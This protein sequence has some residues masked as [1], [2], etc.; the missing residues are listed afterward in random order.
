MGNIRHKPQEIA[1]KLR[2]V[3]VLVSTGKSVADAIRSIGVTEMTDYRWRCRV[4]FFK[5]LQQL[6]GIDRPLQDRVDA[7]ACRRKP[8]VEGGIGRERDDGP[9]GGQGTA[10]V[11]GVHQRHH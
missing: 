6:D 9:T 5:A 1:A 4:H 2:Q 11:D 7:G 8:E 10:E 3:D